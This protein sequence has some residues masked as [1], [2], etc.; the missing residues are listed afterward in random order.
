MVGMPPQN[1]DEPDT[2]RPLEAS[3]RLDG[4]VTSTPSTPTAPNTSAGSAP[5]TVDVDRLRADTPSSTRVA[6][7]NNAGSA[8]PP[9]VVV[10][11][12]VSH[13]RREEEIGGYEAHA[14]AVDRI[15]AVRASAARLLGSNPDNVALV[16]SATAAWMRGLQAVVHTRPPA[17]GDRLLVSTAEYASNVLPLLQLAKATGSRVEFVPDGPDGSLDVG[18]LA[19]MLDD[20]VAL[21]SV[22]HC[23]SQNG[24]VNDVA[25]VGAALAGARAW[26]LVDA[27]QSVG[28]RPVDATAI[29]ADFLSVT[30]RKFVRGPRGTGFLY[31]SDA[32]LEGLEPFPLDL[33]GATWTTD[34]YRVAPT[35]RRYEY[36]EKSYAAVLGLGAAIDYALDCGIDAIAARI[37]VLATRARDGLGTIAGVRVLDRGQ[38]RSGIVTFAHDAV[39]AADLVTAIRAAG[40]NVSLSTPDYALHDFAAYGTDSHDQPQARV[41]V[42]PHA[43]NT[44]DEI[45]RLLEAVDAP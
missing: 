7:L 27:C 35:A 8:L 33:D 41:R 1:Q 25:A 14:E 42:S 24:V 37:V 43:Y 16:E 26:Y 29:G 31:V 4:D 45:D 6:H 28:Q 40:V 23:P 17:P 18:A 19:A 34:G 12:V 9:T 32:A 13:L 15:E 38:D 39:A 10:D 11:T 44:E 3:R 21:V 22:T 2:F 20:D 36:W 30:G 5:G